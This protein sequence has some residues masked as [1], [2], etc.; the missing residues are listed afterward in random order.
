MSE[1]N[2]ERL[3]QYL[4]DLVQI[5][6]HSREEGQVAARIRADL[7]A[8]GVEVTVD[9]A[10]EKVG[11]DTGNVIARVKGTVEGA[12]P[13]FVA[14]H[15]DTVVPGNGVKPV[16]DGDIIRTDGTTVL[17]GDDKSGCAI[18][19]ECIRTL[20]ER[21]LPH[22]DIDAVFTICEEVGLLGAKHLDMERIESKY[23]LVLD[24]DDIGYLFT[25][26]PSADHM[27]FVI[28]GLEAHAGVCPE[29]GISA[30]QIAAEAISRMKLG[31]IDHETTSNIGVIE[32]GAATNIVPNRVVLKAEARSHDSAKLDAQTDGIR[33]ALNEAAAARSVVVDGETVTA[34]VEEHVTREY[35]AMNVPDD[36]KIVQL[37]MRAANNL[38]HQVKTLATGGGC[39]ANVFNQR[40][41]EVANLGTGMQ[42]IHTV[43]E[44][45][46][47]KD[48]YRSAEV[49]LEILKLNAETNAEER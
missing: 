18:I 47:V 32:G 17:G 44:W 12:P 35:H 5:D 22:S 21:N 14:A 4:L 7:E 27:E 40:G 8:L 42:A 28:H 25:R 29:N 23:G 45:L 1:I 46:D 6:S 24:S 20:K 49:V 33:K 2:R 30:I 13:I 31:R 41:L 10:G 26:A 11:G 19:V 3:R 9:D 34:R 48:L 15:M 37:V 39:D 16:I 36:S 38:N 43:K